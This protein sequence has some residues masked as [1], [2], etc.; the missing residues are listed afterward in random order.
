MPT[1]DEDYDLAR[2]AAR[3]SR[4]FAVL[5]R[6]YVTV[7]YQYC[8]RTLGEREAAEDAT[9]QVFF[10]ALSA[11]GSF[12]G[13]SFRSWLFAI[14]HNVIVDAHRKRRPHQPLETATRVFDRGPTPEEA[15]LDHDRQLAIRALLDRLSADQR[16]VI[17]LR[18]AGLNGVEIAEALGRSH[19]S[20]K[21]LQSRAMSQL[22]ALLQADPQP[23]EVD[24]VFP[25]Y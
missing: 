23:K 8:Y 19:G 16:A 5:Y 18:L 20:V 7:V 24:R 14:A 2:V 3:D 17:E 15:L 13:R 1:G 21:T 9:S 22:R 6:R 11:I 10:N 12:G 4:A 25:I